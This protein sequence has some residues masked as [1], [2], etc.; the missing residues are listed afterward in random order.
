MHRIVGGI[1]I[2]GVLARR[3]IMR[4]QEQIDHQP[5]E[6][7]R[8]VTD[9]V[10]ARRLQTAQLQPVQRRLGGDR[11]AV[12]AARFE[13][14]GQHRH[15]RIVAQLVVVVEVLIA[16]RDPEHP[17]A[18]GC[19]LRRRSAARLKPSPWLLPTHQMRH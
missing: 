6:G 1:K 5:L 15:Y 13:L 7:D 10:I 12:L 4:F 18:L 19:W 17:L 14:A 2:G 8:V 11:R 16:E 9:L 3:T